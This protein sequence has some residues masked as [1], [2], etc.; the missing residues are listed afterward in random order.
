MERGF[1]DGWREVV[2]IVMQTVGDGEGVT[3]QNDMFENLK[4]F[5]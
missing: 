5:K 1:D 4:I 2:V 3:R